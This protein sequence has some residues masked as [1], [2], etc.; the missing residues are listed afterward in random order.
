MENLLSFFN[1]KVSI[2]L[3]STITLRSQLLFPIN[4]SPGTK[5]PLSESSNCIS[6]NQD[7]TPN[8]FFRFSY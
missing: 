3:Y 5:L 1:S 7:I 6:I 8:I 4:Q 2:Y